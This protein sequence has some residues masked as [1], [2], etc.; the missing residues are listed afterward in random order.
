MIERLTVRLAAEVA[1]L[2]DRAYSTGDLNAAR[3]HYQ[4]ALDLRTTLPE[5]STLA[6]LTTLF[7]YFSLAGVAVAQGDLWSADD[8]Y[9]R[10]LALDAQCPSLTF[11]DLVDRANGYVLAIDVSRRLG[12][13]ATA[14][15]RWQRILDCNEQK[16]PS[17]AGSVGLVGPLAGLG[18]LAL[19]EGDL[20]A[21]RDYLERALS[22]ADAITTGDGPRMALPVLARLAKLARLEGNA[23][24]EERHYTRLMNL[25][26]RI[27]TTISLQTRLELRGL[28]I[29]RVDT[30]RARNIE[31]RII[32]SLTRETSDAENTP[33]TADSLS[34]LSTLY[35]ARGNVT[36]ALSAATRAWAITRNLARSVAGDDAR[37]AF[38]AQY[39]WIG[40]Q[41]VR[42]YIAQGRIDDAF[43]TLEEGRAQALLQFASERD[44]ARR[45]APNAAWQSYERAQTISDMAGKE[46][47]TAGQAQER[48]QRALDADMAQRAPERIVADRRRAVENAKTQVGLAQKAYTRARVDAE[49]RWLDVRRTIEAKITGP[50]PMDEARRAL[51]PDTLL[52]AFSV[53]QQGPTLFLLGRDG[54]VTAY[55]LGI[56]DE[57]L[58]ARVNFVRNTVS[59]ENQQR[60][61]TPVGGD[62]VRVRAAR[63]LYQSLFPAEARARIATTPHLLLSPD[64]VLW[65]LPFAALVT[66]AEGAPSFLGLE[67]ALSLT[68]SLAMW[69]RTARMS[70][71]LPAR[72]NVIVVGNPLFDNALRDQARNGSPSPQARGTRA[73]GE[74]GTLSRD[75]HVP[76]P[77]PFTEEEARQVAELYGVRAA[78]GAEPTE[79]W[80]R[81]RSGSADIIHLATHGYFNPFRS[82]SS[83]VLLAVPEQAPSAIETAN[84]GALQAWEVMTQ[85]PLQARLIV[86]SACETGVGAKVVGEG[87]VGLTRAFQVAGAR[88]VVAT[89]WKVAD[90]S[91]ASA[92]VAFHRNLRAGLPKH[93]ALRRAMQTVAADPVTRDPYFWAPF[94]LVGD[95]SPL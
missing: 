50:V 58:T 3:A 51:Q 63:E 34:V 1:G 94:V 95:S 4:R 36:A 49:A 35:A 29:N 6:T 40:N 77:L 13:I 17:A 76:V 61:L 47:E 24:D 11:P 25:A 33:R 39:Q 72:S 53:G 21:A 45:F 44:V 20:P 70:S 62:D 8:Y 88:S 73:T 57:E 52:A 74:R 9:A 37:Q 71:A 12:D 93:E 10:G 89:Q 75:G 67:R 26:D 80:L 30:S 27:W 32:L 90:R 18:A 31:D 41:L 81:S 16:T 65:D 60:A 92:M 86:L 42:L 78:T 68:P 55:A 79:D 5:R 48:A 54:P 14:R 56:S 59:R 64:G 69:A 2:G 38:E 22:S 84:D 91:T 66:N 87:L 43:R 7:G 85:L 19:D 23:A 15:A 28:A 83:G 46:V 82:A